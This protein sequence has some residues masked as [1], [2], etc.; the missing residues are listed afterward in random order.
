MIKKRKGSANVEIVL[1]SVIFISFIVFMLIYLKPFKSSP[2][3][4]SALKVA[5][6]K[7]FENISTDLNEVSL[8]LPVGSVQILPPCSAVSLN[9]PKPTRIT[10]QNGNYVETKRIPGKLYFKS[11]SGT[12]FTIY[13]SDEFEE[14]PLQDTSLCAEVVDYKL[15]VIKPYKKVSSSRLEQLFQNYDL[16]YGSLKSYFGLESDFNI[17]V[18]ERNGTQISPEFQKSK[19]SGVEV[20]AKEIPIEILE[21]NGE[22]VPATMILQ[23]W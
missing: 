15:G 17:I 23:V 1:A 8:K 7:I 3:E 19:A 13:Y 2:V 11:S 21:K 14:I 12:F 10:D 16:N 5:E 20:F 4:T 6:A 9:I 18:N 22:I